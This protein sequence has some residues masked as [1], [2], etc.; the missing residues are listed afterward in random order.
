MLEKAGAASKPLVPLLA[1]AMCVPAAEN[2]TGGN[3]KP[4]YAQDPSDGCTALQ[5]PHNWGCNDSAAAVPLL[6]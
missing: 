6:L 1:A 3:E 5:L 4:T 2:L